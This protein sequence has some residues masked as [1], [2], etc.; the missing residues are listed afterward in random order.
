MSKETVGR[1]VFGPNSVTISAEGPPW[2][3]QVQGVD[4]GAIWRA[5]A[6]TAEREACASLVEAE[7]CNC[8]A[9]AYSD[10]ASADRPEVSLLKDH[11]SDCPKALAAAIR[12]RGGAA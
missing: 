3:A 11:F 10:G 2:D 7:D 1:V 4:T 8:G 5:G 12:A 6:A 9:V